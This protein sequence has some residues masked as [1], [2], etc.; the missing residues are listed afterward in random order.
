MLPAAALGTP[1]E[2][3]AAAVG[4]LL[5]AIGRHRLS[6]RGGKGFSHLERISR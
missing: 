3:P 1:L 2:L 4:T 6:D 5:V